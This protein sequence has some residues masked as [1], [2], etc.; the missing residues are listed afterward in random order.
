MIYKWA[1]YG[2]RIAASVVMSRQECLCRSAEQ[3]KKIEGHGPSI[4]SNLEEVEDHN[5]PAAKRKGLGGKKSRDTG[6]DSKSRKIS[7]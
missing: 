3:E 1:Q 6:A 7:E 5:A 2:W 4:V